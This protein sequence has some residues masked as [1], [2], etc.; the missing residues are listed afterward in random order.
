LVFE[1]KDGKRFN[2]VLQ[3]LSVNGKTVCREFAEDGAKQPESQHASCSDLVREDHSL[4]PQAAKAMSRW[5]TPA[6]RGPRGPRLQW[7]S[8]PATGDRPDSGGT[9][10]FM[11]GVAF[12]KRRSFDL[13]PKSYAESVS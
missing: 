1:H 11:A 2:I 13:T 12:L 8:S 9:G 5:I 10:S 4:P 6:A 3:A 7:N